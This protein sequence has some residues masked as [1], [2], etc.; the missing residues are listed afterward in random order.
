MSVHLSLQTSSPL[1]V[2]FV[3][4][5]ESFATDYCYDL[6]ITTTTPV[7]VWSGIRP[8]SSE[9]LK[10]QSDFQGDLQPA[11]QYR[12]ATSDVCNTTLNLLRCNSIIAHEAG[13]IFYGMNK[14]TISGHW[15]WETVATWFASIG[16]RSRSFARSTSSCCSIDLHTRGRR[17]V[18]TRQGR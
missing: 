18:G 12:N 11:S 5:S 16:P 2:T 10:A 8:E 7:I 17:P 6:A 1:R 14:F 4:L 3:D 15:T 13:S 9:S